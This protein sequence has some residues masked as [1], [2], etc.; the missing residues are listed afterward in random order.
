M[1]TVT[2]PQIEVD[3]SI[4]LSLKDTSEEFAYKMKLYTAITLYQK[5]KLSLG[6]AAQFVGVDRLGFIEILRQ[7]K[8]AIFDYSNDEMREIADDADELVKMLK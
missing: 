3:N 8:I 5:Q 1:Q 6:K 4:L 2:L 7:E